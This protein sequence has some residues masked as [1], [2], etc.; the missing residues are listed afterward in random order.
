MKKC[1]S[2]WS[3]LTLIVVAAGCTNSAPAVPSASA[4]ADPSASA[5]LSATAS[6]RS[7]TAVVP[8]TK[9]SANGVTLTSPSLVSP[10]VNVTIKFTDQPITLTIKN[11]VSTGSTALTYGVQVASDAAF[12]SVVY[13]KDGIAENSGGQTSQAIDKLSGA[14]SYFWRAR[15]TA[16]ALVGAYT[17]GR[18]FAVGPEVVL[19]NPVLAS[20]AS[21]STV[22]GQPQLIV[23]DVGRS[24]PIGV[25]SY[26]FEL[27]D[28]ASF[29]NILFSSSVPEQSGQTSV[30]VTA[31]LT[32]RSTYYWRV[33]A[34]DSPSGVSTAPSAVFSFVA[35]SF[36]MTKAIIWDNPQDLGSWAETATITSINFTDVA[37]ETD[38]D[39][40]DGPGRWPDSGFGAGSL[41]YTLG[42]CVNLSGVW[43]C[44]ATVQFWYG[45]ELSASGRPDQIG[46]NWWYDRRWGNLLGYQPAWGETVGVFVAAGNLRDSGNSVVHERSKVVLIPWG[47]SYSAS[48]AGRTLKTPRR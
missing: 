17:A 34:S 22:F 47:T 41:E 2:L 38:F 25:I 24:G 7:T 43:N 32:D 14:K 11:A 8:D 27:A 4:S 21:G 40:R 18:G 46:L 45:R 26:L 10:A 31:R 23:N 13:T 15:A 33:T 3:V 29:T 6:S 42:L 48:K 36:D 28:S 44:S 9:V 30:A 20:P 35:Q 16:G 1:F 37:F 12:T 5:A 39:K 19:Q